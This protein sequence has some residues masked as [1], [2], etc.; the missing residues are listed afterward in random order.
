MQSSAT[1][2]GW[3]F[4]AWLLALTVLAGL[5]SPR[6][7]AV[8]IPTGP[9]PPLR[10]GMDPSFLPFEFYPGPD[11]PPLGY[12]VDLAHAIGP[13]IGREVVIVPMAYD[14]LADGL[15]TGQL[16]LVISAFPYDPR[17]T[18]DLVFT[19]AYFNAGPVRVVRAGQTAPDPPQRLAVEL[20]TTSDVAARRLKPTP[21]TVLRLASPEAV[22]AAV[23]SGEADMALLDMVTALQAGPTVEVVGKPVEDEFYVIATRKDLTVL[24]TQVNIALETLRRDGVLDQLTFK[25][26]GRAAP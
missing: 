2:L 26:M 16:D 23:V 7:A 15:R 19:G 22:I 12:D 21:A 10:V 17:L 1:R 9:I 24:F 3:L 5:A 20:G 11:L 25:W 6:T 13:L 4:A 14:G 8:F 18:Q